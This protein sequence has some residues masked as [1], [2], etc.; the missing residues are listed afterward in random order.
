[1][2][3]FSIYTIT[4]RDIG[5]TYVGLT[6]R[7]PDVRWR[8]HLSAAKHPLG[9]C[10]TKLNVEMREHG[11]DQFDFKVIETV[12]RENDWIRK[13]R[14]TRGGCYNASLAAWPYGLR[15]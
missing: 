13:F 10:P 5:R 12:G 8:E 9:G 6:G 1:M 2:T 7:N 15:S 14:E 11:V 4:R 3:V